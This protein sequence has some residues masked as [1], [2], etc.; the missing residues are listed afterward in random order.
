[1]LF[2]RAGD[3][4]DLLVTLGYTS[5]YLQVRGVDNCLPVSPLAVCELSCRHLG[6]RRKAIGLKY[7]GLGDAQYIYELTI[8]SHKGRPWSAFI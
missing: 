5:G 8:E 4:E 3:K 6:L 2:S 1:M 7:A